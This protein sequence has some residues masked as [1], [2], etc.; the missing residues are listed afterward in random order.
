M[1]DLPSAHVPRSRLPRPSWRAAAG[2]LLAAAALLPAAGAHAAVPA[3]LDTTPLFTPGDVVIY[4]VGSGSGALSSAA[5]PVFLDEYGPQGGSAPAATVA[6]PTSSSGAS[7]TLTASGTATS[8]GLLTLSG[9]GDELALTGYDAPVGTASV[10]GTSVPRTV[11]LVDAAGDV[12]TSTAL[13]DFSPGNNPRS[14][15][16]ADGSEVWVGGAAGGVRY[17]PVGASTSTALNTTDTNVRGVEIVD[18]QLY[19]DADP[20]K[21]HVTVA[22]VGSGLPTS[23][24]QPIT[25]LPF[26]TAPTEP[27]GYALLTLGT[28][29]GP[30]TLY[31][32]DSGN[33]V[34]YG[35]QNGSWVPEGSV[36]VGAGVDGLAADDINGTATIYVTTN[37]SSGTSGSLY[38]LSDPTGQAGTLS[39]SPQLIA[40]APAGEAF[41]GVA[42]APGTTI[43]TG[44]GTPPVTPSI[45][46]DDTS[47]AAALGDATNPPLGFTV[48]DPA[49]DAGQLTV[50]ASSSDP[51]VASSAAVS[52]SGADRTLT[53]TP[54]DTVGDATITITATAPD[55][56]QATATVLYG[57]S[58]DDGDSSD[59]YYAGAG[60]ASSEISVGDGYFLAGDDLNNVIRLY[61]ASA[62][63]TPAASFDFTGQLPDATTS[64]DIE[65]AAR[66]GDVIFWLGS[67]SNSDSGNPRPAADT[68]FAT[69][70]NGS[71][72][73]TTLTYLG[74]YT[75]LRDDLIAWDEQNGDPLGLE[76]AGTGSSKDATG[77]NVEGLEFAP[78]SST[79]AYLAF[80]APLEPYGTGDDALLVP[81]TDLPSLIG[82]TTEGQATF[83]DPIEL[84]LGGLAIREI[85]KNAD[86]QYLII[87]GT[88]DASNSS[89]ALY[90][91][92]GEPGDAPTLTDTQ[93]P[94]IEDG[95][96][97]GIVAVPDPL[98]DGSSVEL[99]EDN[100][101][102]AWYGDGATSKSGLPTG[103]QKDLGRT[104]TISLP[105]QQISFGATPPSPGI[106]G[107][108]YQPD[109][110]ASSGLPV[111]L[112]IDPASDA[113]AC[114]V[115]GGTVSFTGP[116][117]CIIDA[118]QPGGISAAPAPRAQ[119]TV[120]VV[121][122]LTSV[123]PPTIT[124][125]VQDGGTVAIGNGKW[126]QPN[127]ELQ[128]SYRWETCT[129]GSG[130][131]CTPIARATTRTLTLTHKLIGR[132]VTAIVT[133]R[134]P[135]GASA[136]ASASPAGP[137]ALPAPPSSETRPTIAGAFAAGATLT[138]TPGDWQSPDPLR[139]AYRWQRCDATGGG[140]VNIAGATGRRY[141][142][143]AKDVRGTVR[144]LVTA[145]D[146]EGQT[147]GP[148]AS[149]PYS[150][151]SASVRS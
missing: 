32:A 80:R 104:F 38:E 136:A 137:V 105:G 92:D 75:G 150:G 28:G 89:F 115:S 39:G 146:T 143:T 17:A 53:V 30:D 135:D 16:T 123:S 73:D 151:G 78:G 141:E 132:D 144:V 56:T 34:K 138:A 25:N 102:T 108:T 118:D 5:N 82:Q 3:R 21:N 94:Q 121:A 147:G 9:D 129:D 81:V 29:S 1:P 85:R 45:T 52:G 7:N 101:D 18:G 119:Q 120:D 62:S 42:F 12:D 76:Q 19:T 140:C 49:Y 40:T 95:A 27:Y 48:S 50:S 131:D 134:D 128:F 99:V 46:L 59:R 116:G 8:E 47:L 87:A 64:I 139:Y 127:S 113:G 55:G 93:L 13:T 148:S 142:L 91:W 44:P 106:V 33:V 88:P 114:S 84:D 20:T 68:L 124:G 24:G 4:R 23:A 72:A 14:A 77:L 117:T 90:T 15:V 66:V 122:A 51:A 61:D 109:A 60:N 83:G 67:Q 10:S 111:T 11:G 97:E 58:A 86:D 100:G 125:R 63:G 130:D 22:T 31:T 103:L 69:R 133:A 149:N 70:V 35:L 54:G 43:G 79:T 41:R 98:V 6:L 65:A 26:T 96:W 74:A 107:G 37:G 2:G 110:T 71:G 36:A 126:S 57:L 145:T 112:T